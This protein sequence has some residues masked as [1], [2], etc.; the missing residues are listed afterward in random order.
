MGSELRLQN[1]GAAVLA[2]VHSDSKTAKTIIGTD[3]VTSV[4]TVSDFPT[5]G[6]QDG[7]TVHFHFN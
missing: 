3:I 6:I 5:V 7:D 2:I 1:S 4:A